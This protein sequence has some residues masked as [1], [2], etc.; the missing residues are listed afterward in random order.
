[1]ISILMTHFGTPSLGFESINLEDWKNIK[2]ELG[3]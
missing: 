1:M 2:S 3:N